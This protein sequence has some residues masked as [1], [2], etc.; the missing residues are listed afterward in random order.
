MS[1]HNVNIC[2][3]EPGVQILHQLHYKIPNR[4]QVKPIATIQLR[5]LSTAFLV[6]GRDVFWAKLEALMSLRTAPVVL[7]AA[8]IWTGLFELEVFQLVVQ[9]L[10]QL[11]L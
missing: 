9:D 5:Q 6:T 7:M 1:V 3:N 4:I 10:S 2:C 8:H 11:E